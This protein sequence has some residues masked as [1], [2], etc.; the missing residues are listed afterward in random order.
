MLY[1]TAFAGRYGWK[2]AAHEPDRVTIQSR[3]QTCHRRNRQHIDILPGMVLADDEPIDFTHGVAHISP[4]SAV[5][6]TPFVYRE[7]SRIFTHRGAFLL[8]DS[9]SYAPVRYPKW[10]ISALR[11][12][13]R[14]EMHFAPRYGRSHLLSDAYI[15]STLTHRQDDSGVSRIIPPATLSGLTHTIENGDAERY[16][17]PPQIPQISMSEIWP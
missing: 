8:A 16:I 11:H 17:A 2:R 14:G 4:T 10:E 12:L 9:A 6:I 13:P 7:T 5:A 1:P 3:T 15:G